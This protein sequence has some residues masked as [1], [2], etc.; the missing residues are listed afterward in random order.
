MNQVLM[1]NLQDYVT[2]RIDSKLFYKF[3]D[4]F[5]VDEKPFEAFKVSTELA[6]IFLLQVKKAASSKFASTPLKC[7]IEPSIT[8]GLLHLI[9]CHLQT[10]KIL[11]EEDRVF[12]KS[13][14]DNDLYEFYIVW[15]KPPA[16]NILNN[17]FIPVLLRPLE[18]NNQ[19]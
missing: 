6:D 12:T 2:Y 8:P 10:D 13:I 18:L 19:Q 4:V 11:Y 16:S 3:G 17:N 7:F 1:Q 14:K 15:Y 9:Y 5:T